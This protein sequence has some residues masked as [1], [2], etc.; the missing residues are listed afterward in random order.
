MTQKTVLVTGANG[1]VGNAV[2]K[3]FAR[4]GWRTYGLVRREGAVGDLARSEIQ[5][6]V[7]AVNEGAFNGLGDVTFDVVVSNTED[8]TRSRRPLGGGAG[9]VGQGRRPQRSRGTSAA[10][11]FLERLQGLWSDEA[12][13]R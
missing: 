3:A 7:G 13:A 4:A 12:K 10:G 8:R 5:P 11:H 9:H 6:L 2:V 1:Y